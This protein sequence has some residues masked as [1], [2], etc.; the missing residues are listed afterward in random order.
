MA[1]DI[2]RTMAELSKDPYPI[3]RRLR[4]EGAC[5]WFEEAGRYVITR[6]KDVFE[7]REHL[8]DRPA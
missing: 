2:K 3:Y 6:W 5:V 8:I 1:T 7:L 4:D